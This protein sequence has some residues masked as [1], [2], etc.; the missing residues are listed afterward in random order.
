MPTGWLDRLMASVDYDILLD[1][2]RE[3]YHNALIFLAFQRT[4]HVLTPAG[5]AGK[6]WS[7][8]PN[9]RAHEGLILSEEANIERILLSLALKTTTESVLVG[10]TLLQAARS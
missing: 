5:P 7:I 4:R 9:R 8:K 3:G 6:D 2:A 1:F 10:K